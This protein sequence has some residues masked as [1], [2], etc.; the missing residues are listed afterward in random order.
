MGL[1]FACGTGHSQSSFFE[2][3]RALEVSGTIPSEF[4]E[5]ATERYERNARNVAVDQ[6]R[7]SRKAEDRFFEINGFNSE[8]LRFSGRVLLNDT[9][10]AYLNRITDRLLK[11]APRLR[12]RISVYTMRSSA[13]NAF[14][15]P[16]GMILV[17]LGLL[18]RLSSEDELAFV[19]AHEI[20]HVYKRH[21]LNSYMQKYGFEMGTNTSKDYQRSWELHSYSQFSE[22]QADSLGYDLYTRAGYRQLA[23]MDVLLALGYA[24]YPYANE[25]PDWNSWQSDRF[26]FPAVL[27]D[28]VYCKPDLVDGDESTSTHPA[29]ST[30]AEQLTSFIAD[31]TDT[32]T[33]YDSTYAFY[34]NTALFECAHLYNQEGD[35]VNGFYHTS[36]LLKANPGNVFLAREWARSLYI[37]A[38]YRN[39]NKFDQNEQVCGEA[40]RFFDIVVQQTAEQTNTM[41]LRMLWSLHLQY[42]DDK[43]I[44]WYAFGAMCELV[45][46]HDMTTDLLSYTE[47]EFLRTFGVAE[48]TGAKAD[49]AFL[50]WTARGYT[51]GKNGLYR[52]SFGPEMND[53]LFQQYMKKAEQAVRTPKELIAGLLDELIGIRPSTG[54]MMC[55]TPFAYYENISRRS[56][57]SV[58]FRK[59]ARIRE[60]ITE[61]IV[62]SSE[63]LH[64][65][66]TIMNMSSSKSNDAQTYNTLGLLSEWIDCKITFEDS[67]ILVLPFPVT[68]VKR[69]E[70]A[71]GG[72]RVVNCGFIQ[73]QQTREIHPYSYLL[74]LMSVT[75][76]NIAWTLTK[77]HF[78]AAYY[79]QVFDIRTGLAEH[80]EFL[81]LDHQLYRRSLISTH[82]YYSLRNTN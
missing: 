35:W 38:I 50:A 59:M 73:L 70:E 12:G 58:N 44:L 53:A 2:N 33:P 55:F 43:D 77:P 60:D 29:L 17:N 37:A 82:V 48:N 76:P 21:S 64:I 7:A 63:E 1:L 14:A 49:S 3:Y 56:E 72:S 20:A 23:S 22:M 8:M 42:P 81:R 11:D 34:R 45:A 39:R 80:E 5:T 61:S 65:P 66:M 9:V 19:L 46:K 79:Y 28:S 52:F 47:A 54:G 32:V 30:R 75:M 25:Q 10:T 13:V 41:V 16:D 67:T 18:T 15:T 36:L 31:L 27:L 62:S 6:Q 40:R 74:V 51:S 69:M 26:V 57:E 4:L 78:A 71:S 24:D 68:S